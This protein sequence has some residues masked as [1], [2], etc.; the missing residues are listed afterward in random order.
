MDGPCSLGLDLNEVRSWTCKGSSAP[1]IWWSLGLLLEQKWEEIRLINSKNFAIQAS[2]G[3]QNFG[4]QNLV[5]YPNPN[6]GS[7]NIKFDSASGN[8]INISV[9][10]IRG[11]AIFG[12]TFQNTGAFDQNVNLEN[13]QSGVYLLTV[14]DGQRKETKKIVV[15]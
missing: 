5:L 3:I 12:K 11:R 2:L 9:F 7:F 1:E 14:A 6:K 10:D 8:D 13:I 15:E 4:L